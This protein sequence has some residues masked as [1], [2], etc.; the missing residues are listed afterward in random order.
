MVRENHM[1]PI[2][3]HTFNFS[4]GWF[5][6]RNK[7]TFE[8]YV[9]PQ[10]AGFP[11][12]YLE[13]G[14]FEGM[15]MTWMLQNVLTHPDSRA[16]GVDPWLMMPKR[17]TANMEAVRERAYS[18]LAPW[19]KTGKCQ[20]FRATSSDFLDTCIYR[21]KRPGG[22]GVETVDLC[23]IDGNHWAPFVA[24]D[25]ERAYKMLKSPKDSTPGGMLLFDDVE[26]DRDKPEGMH[27]ETGIQMFLEKMDYQ[28]IVI[29]WKH[30]YMEGWRK[31]E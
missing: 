23:M 1:K 26:N 18:N 9:L 29:E 7:K 6:T 16:V 4:K 3:G 13:I 17:D 5:V 24:Y 10:F 11:I 20:L 31:V 27:V 25:A 14:V 22:I 2:E 21:N 12:T 19:L 15:S 30:R 8:E 28:G